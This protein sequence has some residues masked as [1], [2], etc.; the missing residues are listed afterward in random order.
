MN[1]EPSNARA[2]Q[3]WQVRLI[4]VLM[5]GA[6][7]TTPNA[8]SG[9]GYAIGQPANAILVN[10]SGHSIGRASEA[11]NGQVRT[12]SQYDAR[13]RSS[14]VQHV[15]DDWSY[16]YSNTYGYPQGAVSGPGTVVTATT[17]PDSETVSYTFDAGDDQQTITATPAGGAAQTIVTKVIRNVRGQTTEADFGNGAQ[18]FHTYNDPTD[19]RLSQIYTTLNGTQQQY[20]YAFDANSNVTAVTDSLG[21]ATA[22]YA[23]D[24]LDRLT[25]GTWA[26]GYDNLGNLTSKEGA[27]QTY[28]P[29]THR[30]NTAAGLTYGYDAN[31]NLTSRSDGMALTWN[32]EDMP[33]Q[34]SGGA[35]TTPTQKYF[36]GESVWK[37]AQAGTTTYY[38][39]SMR[40]ENGVPH[41]YYGS[42]AERDVDG[43]LKFYQS[44]RL[45]SSTLVTDSNGQ[46][47]RRASYKP[48]GEDRTI[49]V[50][51]F[52]PEYQFNFKEKE[53]DGSGF[54]DYGAREYN[55]ATGRFLSADS[56][57]TDGLNRYSYVSNNPLRYTDPTG[58]AQEDLTVSSAD[59][60][61]YMN[62]RMGGRKH[63]SDQRMG[64]ELET[65][66]NVGVFAVESSL[67][68]VLAGELLSWG[69]TRYIAQ[70]AVARYA[71]TA[72]EI[73]A[74]SPWLANYTRRLTAPGP[75]S[76][77][78]A[79]AY[80]NGRGMVM[81]TRK[82]PQIAIAQNR[83][84]A[85]FPNVI[86]SVE[87]EGN[88]LVTMVEIKGYSYN[89]LSLSAKKIAWGY[90]NRTMREVMP[91]A[92]ANHIEIDNN[93][94]NFRFQ[95]NGEPVK[96]PFWF[97]PVHPYQVTVPLK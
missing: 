14:A 12:F 89:D 85:R 56:V 41:K 23:Y 15:M 94:H 38:L 79:V 78:G 90:A 31:G 54:Y 72:A 81:V 10:V 35:A 29:G 62:S 34:V 16:V 7:S 86:P 4:L 3:V 53:K 24:S 88:N 48:Y 6:C 80:S 36:L 82:A 96:G 67:E 70:A 33:I 47:V 21:Y 28:F 52:T 57:D 8:T 44:D 74:D 25:G 26:Y 51:T 60:T 63:L 30:L 77:N 92:R 87:Y 11:G 32:A 76:V 37:K 27:A 17:F 75:Q 61:S 91:Y 43:S 73:L 55:P 65:V 20:T 49:A 46:V 9:R 18:Q 19:Q 97:D 59:P 58:H 95:S 69:W 68:S 45:G 84:A 50:A 66:G 40:I 5:T 1:K 64:Q 2:T 13:G 39:P 22:S 93:I 83:L 71:P 42:F